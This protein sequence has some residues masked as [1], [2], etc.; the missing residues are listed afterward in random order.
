MVFRASTT[1]PQ[2]AYATLKA[3]AVQL[4]INLVSI[5]SHLATTFVN[6]DYVRDVFKTLQRANN[7]FT[8]LKTTP[9]I[10][11]YAKDQEGD[12]TYDVVAAIT[13]IQGAIATAL[14]GINDQ[15]PTTVNLIPPS[16]WGDDNT[17]IADVLTDTQTTDLRGVLSLVIAEIV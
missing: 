15:A 7:Q 12:Q 8:T 10:D 4:K 5:E 3:A 9:G 11:Q 14:T 2:A 13:A 1:S 6:Y 16:Q 17:M